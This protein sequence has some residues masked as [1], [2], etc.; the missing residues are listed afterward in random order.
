M[1]YGKQPT[2]GPVQ[3]RLARHQNALS[4]VFPEKKLHITDTLRDQLT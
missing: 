3:T 2:A 1:P 4:E